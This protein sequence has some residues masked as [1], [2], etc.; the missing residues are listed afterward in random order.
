MSSSACRRASLSAGMS[1]A[2]TA[3]VRRRYSSTRVRVTTAGGF[4]ERSWKGVRAENESVR[5]ILGV[6][7]GIMEE[8]EEV[9][10][11]EE[12]V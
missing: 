9:K 10:E 5:V 4:G 7:D 6:D 11:K 12:E 2:R 1:A 3:L 8:E